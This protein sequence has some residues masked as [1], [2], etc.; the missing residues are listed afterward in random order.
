M[1]TVC[2]GKSKPEKR[3]QRR[4]DLAKP[5]VLAQLTSRRM[6]E[7][8]GRKNYL[9]TVFKAPLTLLLSDTVV[10]DSRQWYL[11]TSDLSLAN[12]PQDLFIVC[13]RTFG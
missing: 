2:N 4:T 3:I 5:C 9:T 8:I 12:S 1:E 10:L 6:K 11:C 7:S 13:L